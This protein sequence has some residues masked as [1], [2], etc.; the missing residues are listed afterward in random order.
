MAIATVCSPE[1]FFY[2]VAASWCWAGRVAIKDEREMKLCWVER[3]TD[4]KCS[5]LEY[6][7]YIS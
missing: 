6:R 5:S 7:L 2:N 1:N 3:Y 4:I